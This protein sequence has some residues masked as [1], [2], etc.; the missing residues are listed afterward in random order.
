[1]TIAQRVEA[2]RQ[3]MAKRNLEAYIVPTSDPHQ[4]EYVAE[5]Y[6]TREYI[7]GFTGSAGTAVI[8][9]NACGLWTDGRYFLQA[10]EE[11]K[12]TPF[13]LYRMGTEDPTVEEFLRENVT[14]FGRIGFDGMCMALETYRKLGRDLG[15]RMLITDVD[16]ISEIWTDRP[17][18]PEN[19][20]FCYSPEYAGQTVEEKL[21]ILRYM[22]RDREVDCTFIGAPE[23][24]CY[25]YNIRGW[26]VE[27]TPVFLSYALVSADQAVLFGDLARLPED[28]CA[29]LTQAGVEVRAY[30]EAGKALAAIEGQKIV[31][32]DPSRTNVS[33]S[34]KLAT[35]VKVQQGVNLTTLMKAIKNDCEIENTQEAYLKDGVALMKFFN[36]VETGV[37]TGSITERNACE[38][39]HMLRQEQ[40]DFLEDSFSAIIGYAS[41]AAI[42]H[43]N[44][45]HQEKPTRIDAKHMLLVDSGGHYLQGTTDITRTVA[46]G[47][48]NEAEMRDYTL[49]LKAHIAGMTAKFPKGTKGAVIDAVTRAPLRRE[50]CDYN[51]GT[52]HG[53]GHVLSV[54]EGPQRFS[55]ADNDVEIVP[56][57]VTSME[58]G[59]YVAG[60][61]G[62]R[63]ESITVCI[64]VEE[65]EFG[66]FYALEPLTWVP[67]DTRPVVRDLLDAWEIDWL[68][69]YNHTCFEKL[70]PRLEGEE[71]DYLT[72]RCK[73]LA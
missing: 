41:N 35:N 68:N 38:K 25:L 66:T 48:M 21:E 18:L 8:T 63:I 34:Q 20:A 54:H 59:L 39:L 5:Y 16:F 49:V 31:Y 27:C 6:K 64:P 70:S 36:W 3:K 61:H 58:P 62:I 45:M 24:V 22:L 26:D 11:L 13:R 43:Y 9:P 32:L 51:H 1:M 46:M 55:A 42:V 2:L 69:S 33:L 65:N 15:R 60:S 53:V 10:E 67:I 57:M 71:L 7:S 28:V 56:G 14:P 47:K 19:P 50:C 72:E 29:Q 40:E 4:S 44:P 73:P 52:G 30:E 37:S 23:D 12:D 17:G